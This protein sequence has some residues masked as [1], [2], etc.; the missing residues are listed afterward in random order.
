MVLEVAFCDLALLLFNL[1]VRQKSKLECLWWSKA[2]YL[3][4]ARRAGERLREKKATV[5]IPL[6]PSKVVVVI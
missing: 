4:S 5:G 1:N 3:M 2:V 6:T